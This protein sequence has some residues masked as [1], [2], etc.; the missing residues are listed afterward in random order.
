MAIGARSSLLPREAFTEIVSFTDA[1][2]L[3]SL[4]CLTKCLLPTILRVD[5][6]VTDLREEKVSSP[7]MWYKET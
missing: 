1:R 6:A 5:W 2:S 7:Y 3:R 4:L